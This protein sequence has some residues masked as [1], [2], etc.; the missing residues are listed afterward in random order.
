MRDRLNNHKRDNSGNATPLT[1]RQI[2]LWERV[3]RDARSISLR[4]HLMQDWGGWNYQ[5]H[6]DRV[7]DVICDFGFGDKTMFGYRRRVAATFHDMIEDCGWTYNDI[8]D[9]VKSS[10]GTGWGDSAVVANICFALTDEKGRN[11]KERKPDKLYDEMSLE[12]DYIVVKNADRIVNRERA[13]MGDTYDREYPG[14]REKL[15]KAGDCDNMW[16]YLDEIH[17]FQPV[18]A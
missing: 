13:G 6:L 9:F 17:N 18:T 3:L 5:V 8:V 12:R 11:R 16:A 7:D 14:Y 15:Y 2:I 4:A 10:T 1:E